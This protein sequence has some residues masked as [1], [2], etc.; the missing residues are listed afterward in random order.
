MNKSSR[1]RREGREWHVFLPFKKYATNQPDINMSFE[2][3]STETYV[4]ALLF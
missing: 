1:I 2:Y 3:T 4:R